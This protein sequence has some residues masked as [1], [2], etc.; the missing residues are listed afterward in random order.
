MF[1]RRGGGGALA[2]FDGYRPDVVV[3]DVRMDGMNGLELLTRLRETDP[4]LM[5]LVMT[6]HEDMKT[7]VT[8]IKEGALDFLVKPVELEA[9]ELLLDRAIR[10]RALAARAR[11]EREA[12]Q[13]RG[14]ESTSSVV[15]RP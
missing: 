11:R 15:T 14:R 10:D 2:V 5:V 1:R 8:A 13:G 9:L 7:A 6:A 4:D 12:G 3:T